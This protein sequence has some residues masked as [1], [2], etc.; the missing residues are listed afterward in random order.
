V[1]SITVAA[2]SVTISIALAI[3]VAV[4]T[5]A[6]NISQAKHQRT[7]AASTG[8]EVAGL[9][10]PSFAGLLHRAAM[11]RRALFTVWLCLDI[12][13]DSHVDAPRGDGF[14]GRRASIAQRTGGD[15]PSLGVRV[16]FAFHV[17]LPI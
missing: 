14:R 8:P 12:L 16:C 15:A 10:F 11:T 3:L 6:A 5:V 13:C 1:H 4:T 2:S 7:A 9:V 17:Y